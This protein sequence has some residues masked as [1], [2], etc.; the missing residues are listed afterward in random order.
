MRVCV[1]VCVCVCVRVCVCVCVCVCSCYLVGN[2]GLVVTDFG[3]KGVGKTRVS[4][5]KLPEV[6][7][8][9]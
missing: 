8:G 1:C 3:F 6:G 2:L 4:G 5:K 7:N 9:G